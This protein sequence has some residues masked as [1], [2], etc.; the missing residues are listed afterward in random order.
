MTDPDPND[1][2]IDLDQ[3]TPAGRATVD[4]AIELLRST[5]LAEIR[6]A[7]RWLLGHPDAARPGLEAALATP[8]AQAAAVLLGFIGDADSIPW[9]IEAHKR[10]GEGLQA[11]A[12][13][14]LATMMERGVSEAGEALA[15][16]D[17]PRGR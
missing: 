11:A 2:A 6:G 3:W 5:H 7:Q 15:A 4:Y 8:S 13:T 17:G 10:G 9:L 12:R 14:G 16:F 1:D